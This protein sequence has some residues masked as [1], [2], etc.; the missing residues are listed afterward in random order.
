M[1]RVGLPG[2]DRETDVED[3]AEVD[4]A[5]LWRLV[6]V[7]RESPKAGSCAFLEE[8]LAVGGVMGWVESIGGET[9]L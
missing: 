2:C 1:G 7:G 6:K 5:D 9:V 8:S 3:V 4:V